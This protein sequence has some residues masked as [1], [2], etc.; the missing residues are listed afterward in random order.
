M[1]LRHI[2]SG[3]L[4]AAAIACAIPAF[5]ACT[6][7]SGNNKAETTDANA[8]SP[9]SNGKPGGPQLGKP[10]GGPAIDKSSDSTLQAMI[11]SVV[12]QFRQLSYKDDSTGITMHY[13]LYSPKDSEPGKNYPL[14]L[15][16]ADA[17]TP[18]DNVTLPL[19]QGYGALVWATDEWQKDH[20]CY[21]LVPQFSG[22]AV[23]DAYE[24]TDEVDV[25]IRMLDSVVASNN[26]DTTRLYTTGQSMGG[27]IS[28]YYNVTYP[29]IFAASIFVDCHWATD[30]F[31]ELARHRF[32]YFIAGDKG[33]AYTCLQPLEKAADN[34]GVKYAFAEWSAKLPE[35][36]QDKLANEMFAKDAPVNIIEFT[37]GSVLPDD[38]KGSEH[39]YSFDYAYKLTAAR[40]WLFR[41]HR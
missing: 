9:R 16:I 23:N 28:M 36:E 38:G 1:N 22:V 34:D 10:G 20:P 27:M 30:T 6:S 3:A 2:T 4:L 13:N 7:G 15:F 40:E 31:T 26:V 14:V 32:V 18:G 29:S 12:P 33:R 19:T 37:P 39:M 24:H 25:V 5:T 17:S 21:V 8:D 35:A 11:A 41:Q